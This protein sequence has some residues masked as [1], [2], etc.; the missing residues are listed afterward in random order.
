MVYTLFFSTPTVDVEEVTEYQMQPEIRKATAHQEFYTR[1]RCY[2][3]EVAND[4]G[5][6]Q[7]SAAL[8][9]VAPGVTTAWHKLDNIHERYL[10]ISGTGKVEL[11]NND[12]VE[13]QAGDVVRIPAGTPQRITN[14]G[15]EDLLFYA[16]CT[17]RFQEEYY[18]PLE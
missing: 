5:D 18:I 1:E 12:P 11:E 4:S 17:P 14:I 3:T 2:I 7:L 9:R 6:E 16:V 13:V 10:I 8:A 15:I